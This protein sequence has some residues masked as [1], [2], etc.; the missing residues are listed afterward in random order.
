[1]S[2]YKILVQKY[3]EVLLLMKKDVCDEIDSMP[4]KDLGIKKIGSNIFTIPFSKLGDGLQ[5]SPSFYNIEEQKQRLKELVNKTDN[6]ERILTSLQSVLQTKM[7]KNTS[8]IT[9]FHPVLLRELKVI[10][11]NMEREAPVG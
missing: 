6:P 3:R 11:D 1:M 9:Y 4:V 7:L 8:G 5:L 2:S 10:I